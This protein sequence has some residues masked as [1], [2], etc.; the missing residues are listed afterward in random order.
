MRR[1]LP[2][3]MRSIEILEADRPSGYLPSSRSIAFAKLNGTPSADA[4]M[5]T[6]GQDD[7]FVRV[8]RTAGAVVHFAAGA[9]LLESRAVPGRLP[10]GLFH[11]PVP[12]ARPV[13]SS[14]VWCGGWWPMDPNWQHWCS[15]V[16]R[17]C[18]TSQPPPGWPTSGPA[19]QDLAVAHGQSR[20]AGGQRVGRPSGCLGSR[21]SVGRRVSAWPSGVMERPGARRSGTTARPACPSVPRRHQRAAAPG[22]HRILP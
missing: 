22:R 7:A 10:A 11:C 2:F 4:G 8:L 13:S 6:A 17:H 19:V 3:G 15:S 14:D 21:R 9:A 18:A 16:V 1:A 12:R 5:A 20:R